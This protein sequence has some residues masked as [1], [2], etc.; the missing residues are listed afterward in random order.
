MTDTGNE[1][2]RLLTAKDAARYLGYSEGTVRNYASE[3]VIPS[4]KLPTGGLR[5]RR[6]ELDVW[7]ASRPAAEPAP[8]GT[9]G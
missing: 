7:I 9:E 3:G 8:T 4:V 5:F 6:S 1:G 2:D